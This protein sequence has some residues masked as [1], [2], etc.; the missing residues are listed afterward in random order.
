MSEPKQ[1]C[2]H[3]YL[4]YSVMGVDIWPR[5]QILMATYDNHYSPR[6]KLM[7][8]AVMNVGPLHH[9]LPIGSWLGTLVRRA[10]HQDRMGCGHLLNEARVRPYQ[11]QR[12]CYPW[13]LLSCQQDRLEGKGR[14]GTFE[15]PSLPL[16]FPLSP[17]FH[18][19]SPLIYKREGRAPH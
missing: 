11:D 15:G 4:S 8:S 6:M 5:T 9:L 7:S 12:T 3:R 18:P 14:P 19:C 1:C 17:I 2:G 10:V 16:V 13:H